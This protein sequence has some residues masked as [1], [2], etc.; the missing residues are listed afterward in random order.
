MRSLNLMTSRRFAGRVFP[1]T[2]RTSP[3]I[4]KLRSSHPRV[5]SAK[6]HLPRLV[7]SRISAPRRAASNFRAGTLKHLG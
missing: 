3:P 7:T 1:L 6:I 5:V 4:P 2:S